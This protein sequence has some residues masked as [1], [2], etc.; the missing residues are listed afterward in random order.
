MIAL[1]P[2]HQTSVQVCSVQCCFIT[3]LI[4]QNVYVYACVLGRI[5]VLFS[6][7]V[8]CV[9]VLLRFF[10]LFCFGFGL[11]TVHVHAAHSSLSHSDMV[12]LVQVPNDGGP[13]GIHVVPFSARGG[14]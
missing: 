7:V 1:P 10:V 4:F 9:S 8:C 14:R 13:L 12:K 11:F 3:M 5:F 6:S 2:C